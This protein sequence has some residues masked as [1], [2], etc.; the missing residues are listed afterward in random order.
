[1]CLDVADIEKRAKTKKE[2]HFI[3]GKMNFVV[4]VPIQR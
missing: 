4:H 1:M 3:D 2:T